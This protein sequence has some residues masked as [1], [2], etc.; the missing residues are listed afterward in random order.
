MRFRR[1]IILWGLILLAGCRATEA[2]LPAA[3]MLWQVQTT[4]SLR[5]MGA[6]FNR[7]ALDQ[8]KFALIVNELPTGAIDNQ[9]ADFVFMW[10]QPDVVPGFAAIIGWDE[11]VVVVHPANPIE[12]LRLRDLIGIYTGSLRRWEQVLPQGVIF[13]APLQKYTYPEGEDVSVLFEAEVMYQRKLDSYALLAP[14]AAAVL[15]AVSEEPGGI[16]YLPRRWVDGSVKAI[17]LE[18]VEE[19]QLRR[20]IVALASQEPQ[21]EKRDWLFCVQRQI[22]ANR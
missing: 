2:P 7:C 19:Q 4:A 16:G 8:E 3:P 18:G 21:G 5:W 12:S 14:D 22:S 9:N 20:P 6:A 1:F 13:D 10:G 15:Q 11:L 17:T